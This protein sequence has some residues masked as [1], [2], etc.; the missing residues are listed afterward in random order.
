MIADND[1]AFK[2]TD[3]D[4][5]EYYGRNATNNIPEAPDLDLRYAVDGQR[6]LTIH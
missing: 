6:Q 5:I 3:Q 1:A 2:L 4:I